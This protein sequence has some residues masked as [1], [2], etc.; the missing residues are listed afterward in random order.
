MKTKIPFSAK[1]LETS[2]IKRQDA[3]FEVGKSLN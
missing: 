3:M 2:Q 1:A